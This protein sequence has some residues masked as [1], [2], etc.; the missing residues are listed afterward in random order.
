MAFRNRIKLAANYKRVFNP[1]PR[2]WFSKILAKLGLASKFWRAIVVVIF[3]VIVYFLC[4]SPKFLITSVAVEGNSQVST[5]A[6]KDVVETSGRS[7]LFFI[8]KNSFFLMTQG[9]INKLLTAALP[10]I[11]EATSSRTWPNQIKIQIKERLPGFVIETNGNY[12]LVDEDGIVVSQLDPPPPKNLLIVKDQLTEDFASG[13]ALSNSKLSSFVLSLNRQWNGKV[14]S[15]I[16]SIKFPGKEST[17]VQFVS[18]EGWSV[19]FDTGR[20]VVA[21][22][23][24]LSVLL[25]KQIAPKDRS[26]LAY[27]DLRLAKWAYYC[28]NA[29]PCSQ[30]AQEETAGASI[31]A[32]P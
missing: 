22:L 23:N 3:L 1:N 19:M 28:F 26:R 30:Q 11:K 7:R 27:I 18:E 2:T 4:I 5:E 29:T 8:K 14:S 17:D 13:E 20:S 6:I 10:T 25:N 9:R 32:K 12:F 31:D 16:A 21:Q 15:R 24:S